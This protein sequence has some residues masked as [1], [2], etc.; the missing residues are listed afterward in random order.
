[1]VI[2]SGAIKIG[3]AGEFDYSGSQC[4]KALKEEG[5]DSVL[6]NPNIATIQTSPR[7]SDRIHFV[8]VSVESVTG[9]IEKER[10]DGILLGFG[11]QTALNCGIGLSEAGVFDRYGVRV[12]GTPIRGI[13][14]TEDRDLFKKTMVGCDVPVPRSVAVYSFGEA[15]KAA[16]D[17]GFPVMIRVAY[18][19]GGKGGGVARNLQELSQIVERGLNSSLARQVLVEEYLGGWKQI[20]YEIMRDRDD[21]SVIICNMENMLGM[22][23]HTGDNIVVAPSQTLTNAE[24]HLLRTASLRAAKTCGIVGECNI[25]FALHP[26]S[27]RYAAIEI[28]AR[29]SRSSALASKA[30]GYPL[31]YVAAKLALGYHLT[32]LKNRVSGTTTALFEP[33]LDYLVVKMPRWDTVKFDG[34]ARGI[35]TS[36]KSIGE[37]MAV[38]RGFEEAIQKA[39]RMANPQHDGVVRAGKPSELSAAM[40]SIEHPS[41]TIAFDLA[42]ALRAGAG[43]GDVAAKS[44]VDPWFVSKYKNVVDFHAFLESQPP[45][46]VPSKDALTKA[47]KLGFSDR[48][49]GDLLGM[50]EDRVREARVRLGVTPVTKVI[51]TLAA[52]WPSRT[53]YLYQTFDAAVDEAPPTSGRKVM[54]LGAGPYRIGSS[55]EF[56]WGTMNMAW[57]L[58]RLGYEVVVVNCNPETV[59]TDFDMSDRLYFEELTVERLLAIYDKEK[60]EGMVLCV[61][62]QTPNDLAESLE[63]R[64]V[65]ILGTSSQSIET[66]EDR[67][68]FSALLDRLGIPQPAWGSFRSPTEAAIF[69]SRVGY[70]VIV[71]PSHVLS[72]SA[73]RVIWDPSELEVYI[74]KAAMVNPNYPVVVSEFIEGAREVEV[75]AVSDGKNTVI[76]AIIEHVQDAGIHSGDAI[77]SIPTVSVSKAAKE[78]IRVYTRSIAREL[79]ARGPL[80]IQ[81]LVRGTSVYV[82]ECNLRASRSLPYVC[83]ATGVNLVDVVAPAIEGG[84]LKRTTDVEEPK[85]FAVK[86]PMF[87]FLQM[88]GA[89]PKLG[90]EM[91][92]TGEVACFGDTFAE[93]LSQ[94]FLAT[95]HKMPKKGD[96]GVMLLEPWQGSAG[97]KPLLS[98]FRT[99][100]IEVLELDEE[101]LASRMT[102]VLGAIAGGKVSFVLSFNANTNVDSEA[103][104]RV[105][106]KAV[107]LQ[108]QVLSTKEEAEALLLCVGK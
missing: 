50:G 29:L 30:T 8:P 84:S 62:G 6:V 45:G 10:P 56:D 52:E 37:V 19:L 71:R 13:Q 12:L 22:R 24:Y 26:G 97:V 108:V 48:Q 75:D 7:F 67:T 73:M 27:E 95:G 44:E 57:A 16:D 76:G 78:K 55:V 100:G 51:D 33:S 83:K 31:A 89:D 35:G 93:A 103:F 65:T 96:V 41:D 101:T 91:R 107:D 98:R 39:A 68:K 74:T 47:K 36:M 58:K 80:N 77:M 32:E 15:K 66:A 99:A 38:G 102:E 70:P 28:N 82:I 1:M 61:G 64:G 54:V 105:R 81:F 2:G 42:E 79:K 63:K 11:G 5:V 92:S 72:G 40:A 87:S 85:C 18:T 94:A 9:V 86:A 20:E 25:Q 43:E 88:D 46:A 23:V 104:H 4:L 106:R 14:L 17:L 21:N 34:A 90:V 60:P 3:E 49:I 69:C 59:S 53:N